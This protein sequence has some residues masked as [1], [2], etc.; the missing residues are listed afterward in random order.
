MQQAIG[1]GGEAKTHVGRV[2]LDG[3]AQGAQF[4]PLVQ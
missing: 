4:S 3:G 2:S 1:V